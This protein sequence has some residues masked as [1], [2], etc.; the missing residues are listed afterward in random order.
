[1]AKSL[2]QIHVANET[3]NIANPNDR[4]HFD[5]AGL[6]TAQLQRMVRCGTYHKI[7][8]I[9]MSLTSFGPATSGGQ[10]SG[11][12]KY[13]APTK[14]RCQ[15]FRSAFK[16]CA[17]AMKTQGINMRDNRLYDFKAPLS[18]NLHITTYKNGATLN[19]VDPLC[20]VSSVEGASIF[21]VHN[22]S[23]QPQYTDTA[24]ALNPEGFNTLLQVGQGSGT[25]FV[26]NDT[27]P[28]SGSADFAD[29]EAE[30]IPFMMTWEPGTTNV[31]TAFQWR[32]DPALYLAVMGGQFQ[33]EF[34]NIERDGGSTAITV[35]V[36]VM[37]AGW[38][39]IMGSPDK[40]PR[41]RMKAKT[42]GKKK[43]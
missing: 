13:Y 36:A 40:K 28:F 6:L 20:F 17:N 4:V 29:E 24:A 21:G 9:D 16:A 19:G 18:N 30:D 35:N 42:S 14:G 5:N 22:A 1:M 34:D 33:I 12:I 39:S 10:V 25:D 38:K 7:V 32:P 31:V 8:G 2:G 11:R 37:T 23:V 15:A 27:I 26:L 43:E 3:Y 41:R